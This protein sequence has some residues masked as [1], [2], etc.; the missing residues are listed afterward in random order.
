MPSDSDCSRRP[1]PQMQRKHRHRPSLAC[2]GLSCRDD[3]L[4]MRIWWQ[5]TSEWTTRHR[6]LRKPIHWVPKNK[7]QVVKTN[8]I[9]EGNAIFQKS[10]LQALACNKIMFAAVIRLILSLQWS[11]TRYCL[12]NFKSAEVLLVETVAFQCE[13]GDGRHRSG[14]HTRHHK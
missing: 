7:N 14:L 10:S 9:C 11:G 4:S 6:K 2:R 12:I 13:F 3:C 5:P 8:G 1:S